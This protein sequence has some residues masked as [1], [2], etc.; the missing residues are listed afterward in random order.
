MPRTIGKA[1]RGTSC[2]FSC[3]A[4]APN[5]EAIESGTGVGNRGSFL[6]SEFAPVPQCIEEAPGPTP[7]LFLLSMKASATR[8]TDI[9]DSSM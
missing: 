3:K 9:H 8:T 5:P 1:L 7:G 2:G 6:R 4:G